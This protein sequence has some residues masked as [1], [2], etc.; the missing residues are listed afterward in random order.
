VKTLVNTNLD[1]GLHQVVWQGF[2][3]TGKQ[4]SSGIYFYKMRAGKYTD[5]RKMIMMSKTS[6]KRFIW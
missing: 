1:A 3:D 2:D 4:I 5:I 6:K